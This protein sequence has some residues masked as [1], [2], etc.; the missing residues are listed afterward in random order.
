M[1][2]CANCGRGKNV[3]SSLRTRPLP[4]NSISR[5]QDEMYNFV[6]EKIVELFLSRLIIAEFITILLVYVRFIHQDD[7]KMK[8]H[9]LTIFFSETTSGLDIS[10]EVI[11]YFK[12]KDIP[13]SNLNNIASG[14]AV[15]MTGKLK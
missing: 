6:K 15:T 7:I 8:Y 5:R 12:D 2:A 4:N 9:S 1:R 11:Q 13:L 14:G 10:N 3:A